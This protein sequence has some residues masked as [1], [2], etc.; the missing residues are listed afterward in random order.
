[1]KNLDKHVSEWVE[2]L[3]DSKLLANLS[4]GDMIATEAKYHKKCL[5][6]LYKRVKSKL[7]DEKSEKELFTIVEGNE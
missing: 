5:T 1:M 2:N 4:E 7:N 3:R 6:E